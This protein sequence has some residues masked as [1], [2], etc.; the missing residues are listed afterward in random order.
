M[1][2]ETVHFA[3]TLTRWAGSNGG[4][5]YLV[6]ATGPVA[7]DI[8]AHALMRRLED[9]RRR[10]FGAVKVAARIGETAWFTSLFPQGKGE[11]VM[12]VKKEVRQSEALG[13]GDLVELSLELL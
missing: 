7:E 5:W 12:L 13:E 6:T 11:W 9:G 2:R 8:A 10:G 4:S 1:M 3:S